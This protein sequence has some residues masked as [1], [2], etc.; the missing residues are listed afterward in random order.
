MIN[1]T[2]EQIDSLQCHAAGLL[3]VTEI[4]LRLHDEGLHIVQIKGPDAAM[5]AEMLYDVE[6]IYVPTV[7]IGSGEALYALS[8]SR[9]DGELEYAVVVVC[10]GGESRKPARA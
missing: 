8:R 7:G 1:V 9:E 10:V 2:A 4:V 3:S 5:F 6:P